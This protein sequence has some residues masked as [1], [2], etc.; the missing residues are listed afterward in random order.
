MNVAEIQFH[1]DYGPLHLSLV[2]CGEVILRERERNGESILY[3]P[4]QPQLWVF[5]LNVYKIRLH[6]EN[7]MY[8]KEKTKNENLNN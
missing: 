3:N 1:F 5:P 2:S 4:I 7:T 6:A 8:E